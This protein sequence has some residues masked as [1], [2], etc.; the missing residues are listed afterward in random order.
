MSWDE[1]QLDLRD[2]GCRATT[3]RVFR[4]RSR[5]ELLSRCHRRNR[6]G[7]FT[8]EREWVASY[9]H[10]LDRPAVLRAEDVDVQTELLEDAAIQRGGHRV[11]QRSLVTFAQERANIAD[12]EGEPVAELKILDVGQRILKVLTS[13]SQLASASLVPR[14]LR[15][16]AGD[17]R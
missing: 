12:G 2:A 13:R 17:Q 3:G 8:D 11:T 16:D 10:E 4:L 14:T 15:S 6:Q 9:R 7:R 1:P 5:R